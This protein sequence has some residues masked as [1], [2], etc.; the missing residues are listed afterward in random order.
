MPEQQVPEQLPLLDMETQPYL[1]ARTPQDAEALTLVTQTFG[2]YEAGRRSHD[3]R[4]QTADRLYHGV[5]DKRYWDEARKSERASL[6]V[7]IVYDQIEAAYPKIMRALFDYAPTWFEVEAQGGTT[8]A[9]A[10]QQRDVLAAYLKSPFDETQLT[11]VAHLGMSVKQAEKYGDGA[12]KLSWD[13]QLKRPI[14][15]WVDIRDLYMSPKTPGPCVDWSP[16]VIER[17]KVRVED[18]ADMRG[19]EGINIPSDE[20]LNY[21]AKL[22]PDTVGD[23]S[24]RVQAAATRTES[25]VNLIE[26]DPS[27]QDVEVL[28][29][30]SRERLIWILGRQW[31]ALNGDNP[32]GFINYCKAPFTLVEGRPY[33]I[34]LPDVLEGDQKYAQG[35][36]NLRLDN[37]NL[38]L[39]PPRKQKQGAM[40]SGRPEVWRP[41]MKEIVTS[42]DE[43]DLY[44][45]DMVTGDALREEMIIHQGA[46]KRT[47]INE[48]A[49]SGM[50]TPSNAN[51]SATGVSQQGMNVA[52][53]LSSAVKNVEDFMIVP[54]LYKMRAMIKKFAPE[55]L[56]INDGTGV[57]QVQKATFD[58]PVKFTIEAASRMIARER[59]AMFLG[60]VSQLLFNDV[61]AKMAG[62]QNMTVDFVEWNRFLHDATGTTKA[63]QFFRPM[64]MEEKQQSMQ[65]DPNKMLDW[66][67]AQLDSQTRKEIMGVKSETELTTKRMETESAQTDVA[68]RSATEIVKALLTKIGEKKT[69]EAKEKAKK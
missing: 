20:I 24:R 25:H 35:I 41:G 68:E 63:Y 44:K 54:M 14:L 33:G 32:Y 62:Q 7:P 53:R 38:A 18:L 1:Y 47:G 66:Q 65:P 30:T 16:A 11:A 12:V 69:A 49:Q 27:H 9:E 4:W 17:T 51:R 29:Y 34:G 43:S 31:V 8:P 37:V 45:V 64:S 56:V 3:L 58:G 55:Q 19:Q 57:Q 52:D 13:H 67:K 61:V 36:R 22:N 40:T 48:M 50:P 26:T 15:E 59:L 5:V 60:P 28:V 2:Q 23:Q 21:L 39:N 42:I 6:A 46:S 10:V